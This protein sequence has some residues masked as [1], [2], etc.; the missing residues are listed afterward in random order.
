[1]KKMLFTVLV[2]SLF[3]LPACYAPTLLQPTTKQALTNPTAT[4]PSLT[5]SPTAQASP[6]DCT[7]PDPADSG[8]LTKIMLSNPQKKPISVY[9][10]FAGFAKRMLIHSFGVGFINKNQTNPSV[11]VISPPANSS[12]TQTVENY[13]SALLLC[14]SEDTQTDDPVY[15]IVVLD[16]ANKKVYKQ[17]SLLQYH[18]PQLELQDVTNDGN[19]EIF[20]FNDN[21]G[22]RSGITFE[23]FR[24]TDKGIKS[25]L[26]NL[27]EDMPTS[28]PFSLSARLLDNYKAM[29]ECAEIGYKQTI[30]LLDCGFTKKNLEI[31][32]TITEET[33]EAEYD[34]TQFF[35]CYQNG[36]IQRERLEIDAYVGMLNENNGL[37]FD[38]QTGKLA[39]LYTVY[40]GKWHFLCTLSVRLQ[41]SLD[42]NAFFTD[43]VT[44]TMEAP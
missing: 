18:P 1:M 40:V 19:K 20:L 33:N 38:A 4:M 39:L 32:D 23:V 31:D 9:L 27:T 7:I 35:R 2:C 15:F 8:S 16:Y 43:T 36:I 5:H 22:Y 13:G 28:L 29:V 44:L 21:N 12:A 34:K 6:A 30:S 3:L 41:F 11:S 37:Q 26:Q 24:L 10:G 17:Q 25:V 42:E 14:V